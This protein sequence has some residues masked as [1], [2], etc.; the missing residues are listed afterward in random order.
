M[1]E[2][3][4]KILSSPHRDKVL[5]GIGC[6]LMG[7]GSGFAV[8]FRRGRVLTDEEVD[9]IDAAVRHATSEYRE[10]DLPD[11]IVLAKEV[12]PLVLDEHEY[13]AITTAG[14]DF[15]RS[16][17][18]LDGSEIVDISPTAADDDEPEII[19][20][21]VFAGD[22]I[23]WDHEEELKTRS[24]EKPYILHKDEFYENE[25]DYTQV[26][27]TY[28]AGDNIVAS[29]DDQI[30]YNHEQQTGP[31]RF[32]HGSGDTKVLYV[33]NDKSKAEYE[34]IRHEGLFSV[35]V[36]GLEIEDNARASDLRHERVSKFRPD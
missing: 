22:D 12:A 6:F 9:R 17:T 32:G 1:N 11:E 34:I 18:D 28:Y 29:E 14:E 15:V 26:T 4:S 10:T 16:I 35:E 19:T 8:G 30:V 24:E 33:R 3:I 31:L 20:Q 21:N 36:L 27:L 13:E 25:K 23:D 7:A 5:I 2:H